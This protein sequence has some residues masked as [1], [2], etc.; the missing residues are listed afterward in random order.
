MM[1]SLTYSSP[2]QPFLATASAD[3]L[4]VDAQQSR[5]TALEALHQI[6][7]HL[8]SV[9]R[10]M[11]KSLQKTTDEDLDSE[12]LEIIDEHLSGGKRKRQDEA[13]D[14]LFKVDQAAWPLTRD[15]LDK[16]SL[17]SSLEGH[18]GA[19]RRSN[20]FDT[21]SL[22]A[23]NQRATDQIDALLSGDGMDRLRKRTRVWRGTDAEGRLVG[24]QGHQEGENDDGA[25]EGIFDDSDFY[26]ALLREL[27]DTKAGDGGASDP[28][29]AWADAVKKA[30]KKNKN[31]DTRASKGRRLR[32]VSPHN[33]NARGTCF[34]LMT[35]ITDMR[36]TRRCKTSCRRFLGR[37]GRTSRSIG[38]FFS[39]VA[40]VKKFSRSRLPHGRRWTC[41]TSSCLGSILSSLLLHN[42]LQQS[43]TLPSFNSSC[44]SRFSKLCVGRLEKER[45]TD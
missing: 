12:A 45:T 37:R 34:W 25:D 21:G 23:M 32:C 36:S 16:W 3:R 38:W 6:S 11:L 7:E 31:V 14:T 33:S 4:P 2:V 17:R 9:Q 5:E 15:I 43:C 13:A 40:R 30:S 18:A 24:S 28:S 1:V 19:A 27:I 44:F 42:T 20:K 29:Y 26:Q 10:D 8:F 41:K 39:C 22:K 35:H